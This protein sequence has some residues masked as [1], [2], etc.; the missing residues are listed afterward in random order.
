MS[1][2]TRNERRYL[3]KMLKMGDGYV[4]NYS[5]PTYGEF[6]RRH[7]VEIHAERFQTY[8]T[9]KAKKMRSFWDQ[10][11][12]ARVATVLGDML[13]E[14]EVDC[15][16]EGGQ[17]D[18]SLLEK[19][20][21]I[22]AR[23]SGRETEVDPE[24]GVERFLGREFAIPNVR[25]LP[26]ED[27]VVPIVESRLDEAQRALRV[28]A[29]LSVVVLCGS[30]LEAVLLGKAR[31]EPGRFN[32]ATGS[33]RSGGKVKRFHDWTLANFID[34]ASEVGVLK[35]DVQKFSHGLRDFRNYIHP[36]QQISS[37][38]TPDEHTAKV[39]FQ[40]LRAA[41]ASVAGER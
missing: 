37:G 22:L 39:C 14:Y 24:G 28:G 16:I 41:L 27:A 12:D 9:S 18:A 35:V 26:I 36:Y 34:V 15:D 11:P 25:R 19:S 1:T 8:G 38:F 4:L 10:E 30:I 29:Y 17:V 21:G 33:P 40:V 2:L 31:Q 6:F 23:L 3:E 5:D 20:R 13:D 7:G 32:S